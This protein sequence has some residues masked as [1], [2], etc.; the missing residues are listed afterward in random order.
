VCWISCLIGVAKPEHW[1]EAH[2]C[3]C[4]NMRWDQLRNIYCDTMNG[5]KTVWLHTNRTIPCYDYFSWLPVAYCQ[6]TT[7]CII[8]KAHIKTHTWVLFLKPEIY[9]MWLSTVPGDL[10]CISHFYVSLCHMSQWD[11]GDVIEMFKTKSETSKHMG[12]SVVS[13][14]S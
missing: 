6:N 2:S 7:L 11:F 14:K 1:T 12:S 10:C 4:E 3:G 9:K 8:F 5:T 13:D